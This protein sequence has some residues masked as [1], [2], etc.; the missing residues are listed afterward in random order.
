MTAFP[1]APATTS[2]YAPQPKTTNVWAIVSLIC[3]I[4]GCF[5]ITP[6]A[7]IITGIIGVA[8][9]KPPKGGK[10]MAITGITLGV[11]WIVGLSVVGYG[12]YYGVNKAIQLAK[13]PAINT[14]NELAA[15]DIAAAS[16][17]S[18]LS[19]DE[20]TALSKQVKPLGKVVDFSVSGASSTKVAGGAD[21]IHLTGIVKFEKGEKSVNLDLSTQN[22]QLKIEKLDIK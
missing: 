22:Q 11:L 21:L 4:I 1:P 10:G 7:A 17:Y 18:T 16:K 9:A 12:T 19:E 3:G 14:L 2:P 20:L 13:A 6:F 8:Q 15:G 5:I